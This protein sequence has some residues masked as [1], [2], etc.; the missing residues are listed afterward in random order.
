ML[1]T[2]VSSEWLNQHLN[3]NNLII[4][5]ASQGDNK[6]GMQS[7]LENTYIKG[8]IAFDIKNDF[9]DKESRFPN[10]LPSPEAFE[11]ACQKLGINHNS[12]IVVYDSLGIYTS[13]RAWWMFTVMGHKNIAVLD[14]GLPGW[15]EKGFETSNTLESEYVTGNFKATYKPE[16]LKSSADILK[17][18][19]TKEALVIDAR[20]KGRFDGTAPEPRKGMKSGHI[21]NSVNL[22]FKEVLNN[23]FYKTKD[24][25]EQ[26][27]KEINKVDKPFIFSCGSGI[28]ACIILLANEQI[29]DRSKAVFD[30]SWT[31]WALDEKYPIDTKLD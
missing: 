26:V 8:A 12:V 10:T 29:S 11:K 14:G 25:L 20:S 3:D 19:G 22:P 2:I 5:D 21:P 30:G 28:T 23:G 17:N 4:L 7:Q 18:I 15:I 13:P 9:S 16:L 31:E 1:N 27:F 24:E 6:S